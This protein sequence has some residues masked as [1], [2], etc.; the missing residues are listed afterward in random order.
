MAIIIG[1]VHGCYK[2]LRKLV[3]QFPPEEDIYFVGDLIDR[4]PNSSDVV[5][6]VKDHAAGVVLGNHEHMFLDWVGKIS[7]AIYG[8]GNDHSFL[9]NGGEDTLISYTG[10]TI[11]EIEAE[12]VLPSQIEHFVP[13]NHIDWIASL[14]LYLDLDIKNEDGLNLFISHSGVMPYGPLTAYS[15]DYVTNMKGTN[16]S[17]TIIWYRGKPAKLKDKYHVFGHTQQRSMDVKNYYANIDMGCAY[18]HYGFL[19]ALRFPQMEIF[20]QENVE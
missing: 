13:S 7:Y 9:Y 6:F 15:M 1:D 11:Q 8:G 2:T 20:V 4:G 16:Y 10:K 12:Y 5:Q 14:P 19:G 17:D 3:E 18:P